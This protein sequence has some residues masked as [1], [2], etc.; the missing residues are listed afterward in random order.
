MLARALGRL[1]ARPA[2]LAGVLAGML[3]DG[4]TTTSASRLSYGVS[5]LRDELAAR[6][7]DVPREELVI[8][9][10]VD[11]STV[12]RARALA[13][14]GD[15]ESRLRALASAL[16]SPRGFSLR[17]IWAVNNSARHTLDAG[18]GNCMGLTSLLIG[19]AR[20]LG[21]RAYYLDVS[22]N[23]AHHTEQEV[24]VSAGHIA[25]VVMVEGRP[26]YVDFYGELEQRYRYHKI[27]DLEATAHYYNNL[28]YELIHRSEQARQPV[29]WDDVLRQFERATRVSPGL[30]SAW[31]NLGVA[32]ARLGELERAQSSYRKALELRP[33]L[34]SVQTNLLMLARRGEQSLTHSDSDASQREE[35]PLTD[36]VPA[37]ESTPTIP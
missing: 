14:R 10:E 18:G 25:A 16:A 32:Q 7:P 15:E 30:A 2:L 12:G 3:A 6:L 11:A 21:L 20:E 4:C 28:G 33:N 1:C 13:G 8:P 34:A 5:E 36:V 23:P 26:V 9:F 31:N 17:Y 27:D 24:T 37:L 35:R 29:R 22:L 19:L